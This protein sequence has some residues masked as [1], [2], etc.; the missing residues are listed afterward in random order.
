MKRYSMVDTLFKALYFA[1]PSLASLGL[2]N[3]SRSC[4]RNRPARHYWNRPYVDR[5]TDRQVLELSVVDARF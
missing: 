1:N 5:T 3:Y 2:Y 4:T